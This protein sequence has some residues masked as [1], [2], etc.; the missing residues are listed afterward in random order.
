MFQCTVSLQRLVK[1]F[2]NEDI[3]EENVT[4]DPTAGTLYYI[5]PG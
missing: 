1:Y 5:I 4:Y 2:E 3:D